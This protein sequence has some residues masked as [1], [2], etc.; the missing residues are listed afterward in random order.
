MNKYLLILI[1]FFILLS[2]YSVEK[3]K[4][5]VLNFKAIGFKDKGIESAVTENFITSLSNIGA[6]QIIERSQL[7]KIFK[8]LKLTGTDDFVDKQIIEIGN[9]AKA[10]IVILGSIIKIGDTISLNARK[11]NV[12]SGKIIDGDKIT[13]FDK[14]DISEGI[15]RLAIVISELEDS[16]IN[17]KELIKNGALEEGTMFP[18]DWQS[19]SNENY[20]TEWTKS[21]SNSGNYSLKISSTK[22]VTSFAYWCQIIKKN[23]KVAKNPKLKLFIKTKNITGKGVSF[24]IRC[25][26]T[27]TPDG[28]AELFVSSESLFNIKGTKNWTEYSIELEDKIN[29]KIKCITVY[30]LMLPDTKGKVYYDDISLTY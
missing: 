18:K 6:F 7:D 28:D 14:N 15:D 20:K 12:E 8:E 25:D 26:D 27:E 13:V 11:I 3:E 29:F 1:I 9:L 16:N 21:K 23:I 24:A 10:K 5:A 17:K 2:A 30:L 22:K 4:I 19:Y